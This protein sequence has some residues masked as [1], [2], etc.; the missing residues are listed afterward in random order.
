[1]QTLYQRIP[2]TTADVV[3]GIRSKLV[4]FQNEAEETKILKYII[5]SCSE[6]TLEMEKILSAQQGTTLINEPENDV[7]SQVK[8][9]SFYVPPYPAF[10]KLKPEDG[11]YRDENGNPVI[12]FSMLQ[13]NNGPLMDY[14][15]PFNHR[16]ES[17]TV[18]GGSRYDIESSPVYKAFHKDSGTHRVG[19]DGWCGHLIK[20]RWS[21]GGKKE[22]VVICLEN[23]YIRQ[24]ILD[25]M[26]L[27]YREWIENQNL[28]Y[29]I[30]G[31][32]LQ[33]MCYCDKSQEMFHEWLTSKYN[34]IDSLNESWKTHYKHFQ[35]INAPETHDARPV[36]SVNR[37]AWYDW[38]EFNTRRFTDYLKW[39]KI[40]MQ[41]FD[42]L[43]PIC[44]GGT[45]SMLNSANSVSGIDEEMI[46]NE[47]DDVILNESGGSPIFSDLLT[48]LS[49]KKKV[50]VD[51]EL[52]GGTH[53]ILLQF[54]HGKSDISKWWWANTPS[55]EFPQ[56]NQSSLPHSKDISLSDINEIL[57]IALD[58]RR[59][60]SEIAEFTRD[61]P[62]IA[63]LYSKT[64]ILQV[65]PQQV[66]SGRT[67]YIDA[68]YSAWEG[69]RFLGCRIGF[70]SENQILSGKLNKIKL[71][72][73][74]AV[75]YTKP[76]MITAIKSYINEGG[77]AVMI[78]ESFMF[79]QY[80][81]ENNGMKEIGINIED[82]TVPPILGKGEKAQNYDQSF[83][84]EILYGTVKKKIT[85]F[86]EDI[87]SNDSIPFTLA[88]NGLVQTIGPGNY[89]VLA[90]F[91][92]GKAAIVH[93]KIGEG[94][95]YYLAALL[96]PKDYHLVFSDL[97]QKLALKRP[98]VGIDQN[99][100]PVTGVEVRGVERDDDWLV[101]ASNLQPEPVEFD[102]QVDGEFSA[103]Q[104]LRSLAKISQQTYKACTLPGNNI[105]NRKIENTQW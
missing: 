90:K 48:S 53:G 19:W 100:K 103:I 71:L 24:A 99:G 56:T 11:F 64:S 18:G 101:Y 13:L 102:F 79:N 77:T 54:L 17:Y 75:K 45:S 7:I 15:A 95:L 21:M 51:P 35:D 76:G 59:L 93:S 55:A 97:T 27:H 9:Q 94:S 57:R 83:S 98:V 84:Q 36:D 34:G 26:K 10:K 66:Q 82:V 88:S 5:K 86:R 89:T 69:C 1:M 28:L 63:I 80:A 30:M 96:K 4:W 68:L 33:Y 23:Q 72:I 46:I 6:A 49:E 50:M 92:D 52:G 58:V 43:T 32:E 41:K 25:Y 73:V 31:Y 105:Q 37:A 38:A 42:T 67:P 3:L 65:P 8:Y 39:I 85:T 104:D 87:F 78:P 60:G 16:I 2:L 12:I 29:N 74:P 61:E 22:D 70:V 62:E 44:A 47:V 91:E 20:D 40:E 14:F 81:Q